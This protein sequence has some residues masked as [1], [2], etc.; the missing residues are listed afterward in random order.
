MSATS[1]I[2][3]AP[4]VDYGI[5]SSET[6][7]GRVPKL[8]NRPILVQQTSTRPRE[9]Q[10]QQVVGAANPV[11]TGLTAAAAKRRHAPQISISDDNHHVTEAIGTMYEDSSY[12]SSSNG[13]P[14]PLSF[15]PS[16]RQHSFDS[17]SP[18][19]STTTPT[20]PL[21]ETVSI[22]SSP[23]S[24]LPTPVRGGKGVTGGVGARKLVK[25]GPEREGI[26]GMVAQSYILQQQAQNQVPTAAAMASPNSAASSASTS[27]T[28]R[29][30][31]SRGPSG[32]LS[33]AR[34]N[35]GNGEPTGLVMPRRNPSFGH[36]NGMASPPLPMGARS[37]SDTANS[38]FPLNDL[39]Y[40][41]DPVSLSQELSNL[42]ALRRMSMDVNIAQDPDLP[43]F[44]SNFGIPPI[45]PT[46]A[47]EDD[48]SRLFW[49][50]A[51]LHPELAPT[52][53]KTFL[54]DKMESIKRRSGE[55]TMPKGGAERRGSNDGGL[56]RKKSMLSRQID[57]SG[58]KGAE[59]Y[60]DG[61]ERL[62]RKRSQGTE[63]VKQNG[64]SNLQDLEVLLKDP[65]RAIQ[66]LSLEAEQQASM[67]G[68]VPASEDMPILPTI[69]PT[70]SLRRSTRTTYRRG[71]LRKGERVPL[72]RRER[73][74]K[75]S[76]TGAEGSEEPRSPTSANT[77]TSPEALGLLRI[78]TESPSGGDKSSGNFSRPG[79]IGRGRV[80]PTSPPLPTDSPP[81]PQLPAAFQPATEPIQTPQTIP[82]V[83]QSVPPVSTTITQSPKSSTSTPSS[84]PQPRRFVSQIASNGKST[85][86]I[87]VEAQQQ[88]PPVPQI[89]ETPP[90]AEQPQPQQPSLKLQ[91]NRTPDRV[92]SYDSPLA[93]KPSSSPSPPTSNGTFAQRQAKRPPMTRQNQ[94]HEAPGSPNQTLREMAAHP[95]PLPG[96][97]TRTDS[98]SFIPTLSEDKKAEVKKV[99][100]KV[101]ID[102]SRKSAWS[103]GF[104]GSNEE[105]EKE[106]RK[107]EE[108]R[109]SAKRVKPSRLSRPT[110]KSDNTR[111]DVLQTTLDSGTSAHGSSVP[112]SSVNSIPTSSRGRE[113]I[114][115]DRSDIKLEEER[116]KESNRKTS[117]TLDPS[118]SSTKKEKEGS[119]LSSIFGGGKKNKTEKDP[120][121]S[122]QHHLLGKKASRELS[123]DPPRRILKPDVDYNWTRFSILEERA[124][125]RMAHIKLANP[126]R[127]LASQV[128]LSNFMYSYLAKVQQMH[129]QI[130]I[131]QTAAA[132]A[133]QRHQASQQAKGRPGTAAGT[134]VGAG[135]NGGGDG[136]QQQQQQ[137]EEFYQYQKYQ[138]MQQRHEHTDR[139]AQQYQH[140]GSSSS[141]PPN[142]NSGGSQFDDVGD[143]SQARHNDDD[144]SN[145]SFEFGGQGDDGTG[146]GGSGGGASASSQNRPHSRASQYHQHQGGSYDGNGGGGGRG[147]MGTVNGYGAGPGH[148]SGGGGGGGGGGQ[149]YDYSRR[150]G[151][152]GG[153]GGSGLSSKGAG[154]GGG[155]GTMGA[156][157]GPGR[158]A[159]VGYG[160]GYE[161][162]YDDAGL[163]L[164]ED[165]D[166]W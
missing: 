143:L 11:P 26:N 131:P 105:K 150:Q 152:G 106:K 97:S 165:D 36:E 121:S 29:G 52:E 66:R 160:P 149:G 19:T 68:E 96:N 56:R 76:E 15:V 13:N 109:E 87:P 138:E 12:N 40:E 38:S 141:S 159:T 67:G 78:T 134:G 103:L 145:N 116:K 88:Q 161:A 72:S 113:S 92:H 42:Q 20:S 122:T 49:V 51:R 147:S 3:T 16:P 61:A 54:D 163:E 85:V 133:A 139:Q 77:P 17:T 64:I 10:P 9:K 126:R 140:H 118:S 156:E 120:H 75:T 37:P 73:A 101:S 98:L 83:P 7:T 14:R 35:M 84:I 102:G 124:I 4:Q 32:K 114:L 164:Q 112:G 41:S 34:S 93:N 65:S 146:N 111:L 27:P 21:S 2:T 46:D 117:S 28:P 155:G 18:T 80:S 53:F 55:F 63:V 58:G 30:T 33:E 60:Q 166:M 22:A 142:P 62:G 6:S 24:S 94:S 157:Y 82:E 119:F 108:A 151:G 104:L 45:A 130:Q 158:G 23:A 25:R 132:K 136:E 71:S 47:S 89:V 128:L 31:P 110:D 127:A 154:A 162:Q 135:G 90:P 69:P 95:S 153:G 43:T 144:N 70:N 86:R 59:G 57:N 81:M 91:T 48:A 39:D 44:N 115:L 1:Q 79:R 8:I 74:A 123:P 99:T 148:A 100:K 125:Y 107:E 5:N 129:P 50:P 137:P